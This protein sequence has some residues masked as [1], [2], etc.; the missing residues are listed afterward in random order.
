M[1]EVWR[2]MGGRVRMDVVADFVL[3]CANEIALFN[4]HNSSP[5]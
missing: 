5:L 3:I 1:M 2:P 4:V